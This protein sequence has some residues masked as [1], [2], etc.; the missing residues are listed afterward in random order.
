LKEDAELR[1]LPVIMLSAL[2]DV[3]RVARCIELARKI[4]CR[5]RSMPCCFAPDWG[6]VL[7]R[8]G[9]VDREQAS[10]EELLPGEQTAIDRRPG[11]GLAHDFQ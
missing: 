7:K 3:D 6:R 2:T 4:T 5:N 10:A 11:G 9:C 8:N 1:H